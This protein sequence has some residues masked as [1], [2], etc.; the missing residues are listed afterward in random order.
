[1]YFK[2]TISQLENIIKANVASDTKNWIDGKIVTIVNEKSTK[3]LY[4]TYSLIASK[5]TIND[6]F[7]TSELHQDFKDYIEIQNGNIRQLTRMYLLVNILNADE[8]FFSSKVANIIEVA[9][10]GELETFLKFLILLPNAEKYKMVAVDA[11][12]T[13]ISTVFNALAYNNPYPGIYFDD[14]QWNQMFL[15]TAFM[16]GDLSAISDI[17]KRANKDLARIISDYAHERWA[18][19]RDIDPDFWRPVT[20]FLSAELLEDMKRLLSS[21]SKI[22]NRAGALCCY[23]SD[24]QDAKNLLNGHQNLIQ[25][26]ENA[27]LSWETIK[28][29]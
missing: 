2:D 24:N 5:V 13:N 8:D 3:D 22:E 23:H 12:R 17:D 15:K 6:N 16:Q 25:Q 9:D 19:G 11:L 27:A 1:M 29:E 26:I 20:K 18:A 14:Q 10:T 28:E 4:L 7:D 21:E